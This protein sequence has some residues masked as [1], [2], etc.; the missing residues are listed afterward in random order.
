MR[1]DHRLEALWHGRVRLSASDRV[2]S[3]TR[4]LDLLHKTEPMIITDRFVYIHYPKTGGTFVSTVLARLHES[5][6]SVF[7]ANF[8]DTGI[9]KKPGAGGKHGTCAEI[10][11]EHSHK[12][13]LTTTRSPY[14][15]YVSQYKFRFGKRKPSRPRRRS[16]SAR[17]TT[18]SPT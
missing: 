8:T 14:D 3:F 6:P 15:R 11:A 18:A 16:R 10:P 1:K 9:A 2:L 12:P 13:I 17:P 5:H 7:G 4:L